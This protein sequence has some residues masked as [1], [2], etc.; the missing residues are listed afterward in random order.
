MFSIISSH[1]NGWTP[2][3][4]S[5]SLSVPSSIGTESSTVGTCLTWPLTETI[6]F[7]DA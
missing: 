5:S 7:V 1:F 6:S 3:L 2:I 4:L